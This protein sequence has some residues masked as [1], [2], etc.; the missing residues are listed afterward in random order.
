MKNNS[1][2]KQSNINNEESNEAVGLTPVPL[3]DGLEEIEHNLK[4]LTQ[5]GEVNYGIE[6]LDDAVGFIMPGTVTVIAACP[7]VGKSLLAQIVCNNIAKLGEKVLYCSCEM[8]AGQL[9]MRELKRQI[10]TSNRQLLEGY[11]QHP[12][13]VLGILDKFRTD[14]QVD[15]VHNIRVVD[16]GDA[17]IDNLIKTFEENPDY[18]YIIVDYVQALEGDGYDER[19]QFNDISKKLKTYALRKNVSIIECSQIPKSNENENRTQKE[20]INFQ[21]LKALGSGKWEADADIVIKMVEVIEDNYTYVLINLS[22]N[23]L[24]GL[25]N[26]TY[27]YTKTPRLTFK[28][29]SKGY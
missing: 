3:I 13:T 6:I 8:S 28:L 29:I 20:G 27:K 12:G 9:M 26:A 16:I 10:G 1:H 21:K 11:K 22:K 14:E 17:H 18:K 15:F 4:F 7:N 25:K 2:K 23:R 19:N 5:K 24:E